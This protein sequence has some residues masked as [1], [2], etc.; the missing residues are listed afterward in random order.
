ESGQRV[1]LRR[2][3]R[4]TAQAIP[5][6]EHASRQ[7]TVPFWSTWNMD[8]HVAGIDSV[9]RLGEFDLNAVTPEYFATLGTRILRGRGIGAEDTQ[10][11]LRAM[12]VSDELAK[13]LWAGRDPSGQR[14]EVGAGSV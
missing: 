6:V 9:S 12:V 2:D 1:A 5:G 8:L 10:H 7:L 13:A 4:E 14:V 3:L 11:A